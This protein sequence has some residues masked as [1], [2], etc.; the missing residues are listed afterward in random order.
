MENEIVKIRNL[1]GMTQQQF[2]DSVGVNLHT[3]WRWEKNRAKPSFLTMQAIRSM[4][5]EK[6][7]A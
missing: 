7:A 3:V 5:P 6:E 1:L 4:C 2:A